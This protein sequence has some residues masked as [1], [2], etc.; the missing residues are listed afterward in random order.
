MKIYIETYGCA[1]NK[2]DSYIMKS[3]L[4]KRGHSITT[5]IDKADAVIINT[6]TVRYDTQQK[7]VKRI[8]YLRQYCLEKKKKLIIAGCMAKAQPYLISKIAP[9]ASLISPQNVTKIWIAVET[10]D[11]IILLN[12]ERD[13]GYLGSC[14]EGHVA[15]VPIQE[16][17]FGNCSFCIVKN[18]RR[19]VTSYPIKLIIDTVK[20]LVKNGAKEV[21][22]T[23]QDTGVYGVDLYGKPM[24][25]KLLNELIDMKEDFMIRIGMINPDTV[26]NI[27]DELIDVMK[28]QKI[29]KFI[30]IPVQSGSNNVLKIMRRNYKVED[31][32]EIVK[33]FRRKIPGILIATDIIIGHPG[34]T[35]HDFEET[36]NLIKKLEIERVHVAQYSIRPNTLSAKLPQVDTREKK[37]RMLRIIKV[38]E[39]VGKKVNSRYVGTRV[40]ALLIERTYPYPTARLYNY[41]PVVVTNLKE[42]KE[43]S[44]INIRIVDYTFFDLRAI[45]DS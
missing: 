12:G 35:E 28:E 5:D 14:I 24:L 6:C 17:C 30:H 3:V 7:M 29:Y 31:F 15:I 40:K 32:I 43:P 21:E 2:G 8:S 13:R 26:K 18:A 16:G 22:I 37:K 27:L 9:E 19:S 36:L 39:E 33:E 11:K 38:I 4:V 1:L 10:S 41:M 44:W 25:P 45:S 42:F 34:E 23:G 20:K